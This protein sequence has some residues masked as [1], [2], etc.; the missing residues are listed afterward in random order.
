MGSVLRLCDFERMFLQTNFR[1]TL[2]E[3]KVRPYEKR[4][5]WSRSLE[6]WPVLP[7]PTRLWERAHG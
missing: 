4:L 3:H 5:W 2:G 1:G 6:P 7:S